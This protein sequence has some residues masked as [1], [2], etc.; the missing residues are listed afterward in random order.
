MSI[1]EAFKGAALEIGRL[2]SVQRPKYV[3]RTAGLLVTVRNL[4]FPHLFFEQYVSV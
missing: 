1:P 2:P 3:A 4:A